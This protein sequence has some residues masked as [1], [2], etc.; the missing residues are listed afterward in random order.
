LLL[1]D[2]T[3]QN[4][5]STFI[6]G[7]IFSIVGIV[8]LSTNYYGD[9]SRV[10]LFFASCLVIAVVIFSLIRWISKLSSLGDISEVIDRLEGAT[11]D[12]FA[13]LAKDPFLGGCPI[14]RAP[15]QGFDLLADRFGISSMW[16]A[17]S[18]A[19]RRRTSG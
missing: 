11:C 10:V 15:D 14:E 6:S 17:I 2:R 5:I 16:M 13:L 4:A 12:A 18:S 3:A 8:G 9:A 19:R 1:Q 7:F